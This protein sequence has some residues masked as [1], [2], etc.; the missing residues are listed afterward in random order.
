[1]AGKSFEEMSISDLFNVLEKTA[2]ELE[3]NDIEFEAAFDEYKDG[4][5]A[6]KILKEKLSDVKAKVEVLTEDGELKDFLAEE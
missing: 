3:R 6:V 5:R 4:V 1:M 2:K